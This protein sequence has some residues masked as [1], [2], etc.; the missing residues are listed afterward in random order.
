MLEYF[1]ELE[2]Q[3]A[4]R[5]VVPEDIVVTPGRLIDA[6]V[7]DYAAKVVDV[8]EIIYNTIYIYG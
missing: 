6:V 2:K 3:R 7:V 1:R 8:M 4:L 5:D